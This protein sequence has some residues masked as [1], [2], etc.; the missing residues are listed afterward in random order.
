MQTLNKTLMAMALAAA[1][2]SAAL[3]ADVPLLDVVFDPTAVAGAGLVT[4]AFTFD[5]IVFSSVAG[6]TLTLTD[7]DI[8]GVIGAGQGETFK[9]NGLVINTNFK[10]DGLLVAP[11][12][13]GVN[14]TYQMFAIFD[15]ALIA[16][17]GLSGTAGLAGPTL[18]ALF[19]SSSAADIVVDTGALNGVYD[20]GTS[21]A[22]GKL[23]M[24]TGNC[25]L[26]PALGG[27]FAEGSCGLAFSF[28]AAG[29]TDPGV[30]T[31]GGID[32]ANLDTTMTLNVDVDSISPAIS[33]VYPGGA[34]SSQIVNVIHDGS[35]TFQVPEPASL[36]LL[37]IGLL[38]MG[39]M[40]RGR[41]AAA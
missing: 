40:L 23:T 3:A 33:P 39:G 29:A 16:G 35:T 10:F 6:A 9:E 12:I 28:D 15:P 38:G 2:P 31:R 13:T 26:T 32:L 5:E 4:P 11:G 19:D 41:R 17:T 8:D 7:A 18:L 36:A 21:F 1:L 34:G 22:I 37:G 20:A 14:V 24:G 30:W 27:S 25:V